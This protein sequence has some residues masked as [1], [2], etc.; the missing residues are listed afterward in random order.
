MKKYIEINPEPAKKAFQK[1]NEKKKDFSEWIF[2]N[3]DTIGPIA[4]VGGI[5]AAVVM[6]VV[7]GCMCG[8]GVPR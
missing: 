4:V 5:V 8:D 6:L 3:M 7:A 1:L 2:D